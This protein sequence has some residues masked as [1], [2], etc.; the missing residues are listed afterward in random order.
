MIKE[1][2]LNSWAGTD[3]VQEFTPQLRLDGN[4]PQKLPGLAVEWL[5][6]S[7]LRRILNL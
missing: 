2:L 4:S 7:F 5:K 6:I 3:L 1:K